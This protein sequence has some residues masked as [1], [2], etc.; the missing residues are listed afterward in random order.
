MS[1]QSIYVSIGKKMKIHGFVHVL[2]KRASGITFIWYTQG[3]N[4]GMPNKVEIF[5]SKKTKVSKQ[6]SQNQA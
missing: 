2:Y 1:F 3:D 4:I 5:G 6:D